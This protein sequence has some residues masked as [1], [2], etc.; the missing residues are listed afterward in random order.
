MRSPGL[1]GLATLYALSFSAFVPVH[2]CLAATFQDSAEVLESPDLYGSLGLKVSGAV[3]FGEFARDVDFGM[4]L[5]GD[6]SFRLLPA[7][8]LGLRI[9]GGVIQYG[10][11]GSQETSYLGSFP[12]DAEVTTDNY[13]GYAAIGPQI[14][15]GGHPMSARVYGLIGM[16]RFATTT[17]AK[18]DVRDEDGEWSELDLRS[19]DHLTDWTPALVIGGE[20]RWVINGDRYGHLWGA[21]LNADWRRHGTTRYLIEGSITEVGGR[22][23]FEPLETRADFVIISLG[24]WFGTW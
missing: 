18:I 22:P 23:S 7:G 14:H 21:S 20:L 9:D 17:S 3:P 19:H 5:T 4:G 11:E 2:P 6:I 1:T 16:S 24:V 15:L 10:H 13:I 12:A 8:W